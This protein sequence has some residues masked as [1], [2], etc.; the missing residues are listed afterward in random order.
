MDK[1]Q[2]LYQVGQVVD[3]ARRA[4][5]NWSNGS[6]EKPTGATTVANGTVNGKNLEMKQLDVVGFWAELAIYIYTIKLV[7]IYYK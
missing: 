7:V 4:P 6:A 3:F 5:S 1:C 2:F